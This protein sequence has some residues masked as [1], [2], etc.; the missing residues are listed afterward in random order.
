MACPY[1]GA[2]EAVSVLISKTKLFQDTCRIFIKGY[3]CRYMYPYLLV[4]MVQ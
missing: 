3:V 4:S 1:G 2:N